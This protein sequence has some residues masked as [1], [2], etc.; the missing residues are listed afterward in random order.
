MSNPLALLRR[1]MTP[2][3]TAVP[4]G[5]AAACAAAKHRAAGLRRSCTCAR[6]AVGWAG[7]RVDA[8]LRRHHSHGNVLNRGRWPCVCC[9][10]ADALLYL[11]SA[12]AASPAPNA[13]G[14][15]PTPLGRLLGGLPVSVEAA[16]LLVGGGKVGLLRPAALLAALCCNTPHPIFQPFASAEQY[17]QSLRRSVRAGG[18]GQARSGLGPMGR[19]VP[20]CLQCKGAPPIPTLHSLCAVVHAI[21][22]PPA[23]P[24]ATPYTHP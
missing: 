9:P 6:R 3:D 21:C 2:P 12:G 14:F 15:Q 13:C 17:R 1:C 11:A 20:T 16:Q 10:F 22:A 5:E 23:H 4:S 19:R 7:A 18:A 24:P 8:L